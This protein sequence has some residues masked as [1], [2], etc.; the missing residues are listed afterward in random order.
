M[1]RLEE[2]HWRGDPFGQTR[3]DRRPGRYSVYL[4]DPLVGR[5]FALDGEVA[6]E[7]SAAE[8]ALARFEET[9]AALAGA[10]GLARL[11]LRA[12][13]VASSRI[14]G[15][16]IGGRRLLRAAAARR[17]GE[18]PRDQTAIEVLGN[19][20]AMAWGIAEVS[21]GGEISGEAVLE[22]HRRL[23]AGT[24]IEEHGGTIRRMQ[25]WIGGNF[26]N[27]CF[28]DFVPPPPEAVPGLLEDLWAFCNEDTLQPLA[29]AAVAHAQFET[30]HPFV[31][32]NGRTGRVLIHMVL[33]RR[34]FGRR[35]L[36]PVSLI[37]A[38]L[39]E[40]YVRGLTGTHY[41]GPADSPEA[42]DGYDYW[43]EFFASAC[44][45]AVEDAH[46]FEERVRALQAGW[47]AKI[48]PARSDSA[49]AR[50]IEAL[51]A[52]PV[53]TAATAATLIERSF[54]ATALAMTRLVEAGVLVQVNVG[55]RHR[56]FEAPELIEAFTALERRLASPAADTRL[57]PPARR[58]PE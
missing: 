36:P 9:G 27:P 38:T 12:E 39:A 58:V 3:R 16:V 17:L 53:L 34:G 30:I 55:R 44:R 20:E 5:R 8:V 26:H 42:Q 6:A 50:L 35:V 23:V 46:R 21:P 1:A 49:V 29:Q 19:I 57:S 13:A 54:Q 40:D 11:L 28:A 33:R 25:N 41:V 43:I 37:L 10:E 2:R 31:D 32:G 51:P 15:L 4:P 24:T 7:V 45:R 14:E 18:M 47:R 22:T 48:G 56:A 52:A